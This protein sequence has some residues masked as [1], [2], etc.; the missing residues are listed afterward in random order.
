[1]LE[2]DVRRKCIERCDAKQISDL[3]RIHLTKGQ[4]V[5]SDT[6]EESVKSDVSSPICYCGFSSQGLTNR[7]F[8][9]QGVKG[10]KGM[11]SHSNKT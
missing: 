9:S 5:T 4:D 11:K 1:M 10:C 7:R 3:Y 8:V 2:G 6:F